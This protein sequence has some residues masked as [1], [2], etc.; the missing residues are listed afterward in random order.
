MAE[1]DALTFEVMNSDETMTWADS[2][3]ANYTD[4]MLILHRGEI[5]YE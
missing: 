2:L 4:G 5:V 1:I 3:M